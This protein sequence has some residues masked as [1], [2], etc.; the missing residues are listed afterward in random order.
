MTS[1]EQ[2]R[3]LTIC[4]V[5]SGSS[6]PRVNHV[7]PVLQV[8]WVP[9]YLVV[10]Q[11]SRRTRVC[12]PRTL[13][14]LSPEPAAPTRSHCAAHIRSTPWSSAPAVAA[15]DREDFSGDVAGTMRRGQEDVGRC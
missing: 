1:D 7:D 15:D 10:L 14:R 2:Q 5:C 4:A 6:W 9:T 11:C 13:R 8:D 12:A 3:P